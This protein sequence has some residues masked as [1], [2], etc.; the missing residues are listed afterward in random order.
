MNRGF[1]ISLI[2]S[3]IS[4]GTKHPWKLP[5]HKQD[6][7]TSDV[8]A[9][10][11]PGKKSLSELHL[12]GIINVRIFRRG[13]IDSYIEFAWCV[14][15]SDVTPTQHTGH[16]ATSCRAGSFPIHRHL[17]V[18][19][20]LISR[21]FQLGRWMLEAPTEFTVRHIFNAPGSVN[22]IPV[23]G[24][25]HEDPCVVLIRNL[26]AALGPSLHLPLAR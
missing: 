18:M 25:E 7:R 1:E 11:F 10:N 16:V 2:G 26:L 21:S 8:D 3:F 13:S 6:W 15:Q 22:G 4:A 24:G 12:S 17:G 19:E 9:G 23:A 14:G 20:G 5:W